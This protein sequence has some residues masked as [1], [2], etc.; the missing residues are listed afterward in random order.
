MKRILFCILF[1]ATFASVLSA[2]KEC[3]APAPELLKHEIHLS[4]G[5]MTLSGDMIGY[6]RYYD[7][8]SYY[9]SYGYSWMLPL[10]YS[11]PIYIGGL[12]LSYYYHPAKWF[13]VGGWA[14]G[15]ATSG[16]EVYDA[17]TDKLLRTNDCF[18]LSIA[19]AVRFS[20]LNRKAVTLYSGLAFGFSF[21]WTDTGVNNTGFELLPASQVTFFGVS[22]GKKLFGNVELGIGM[23][24]I[25]SAG[26]GYRF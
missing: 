26:I 6:P 4:I 19:P 5:D 14:Y 2:Q 13:W 23:K 25:I 22:F 7:Y 24:G 16:G 1:A 20:Y 9:Y 18:M 8:Y 3:S 12:S 21:L 10:T 17:H 15:A 11:E